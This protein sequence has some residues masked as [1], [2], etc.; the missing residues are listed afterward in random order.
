MNATMGRRE[1]LL[2]VALSLLWGGSFFFAE[3]ALVELP[4]LTVVLGRVGF[5][6][7]ALNGFILLSGRRMP[8]SPRLWGAFLVMGALNNLLPFSLI[9]W[10]QVHIDSGLAAILNATTPLFTVLLAHLLTADER[11]TRPRLAGVLLGFA[12]V[13]LMIGPGA[14]KGLGLAGLGQVAVLA[15]ALAYALA[16]IFGRR[17]K[18]LAPSTA[19]CGML[20]ATT[21]MMLP[22]ALVLERPWNLSPSAATWG[23]VLGL[24]LLSTVLAYL[25]YFRILASAGVTNLLLVTFLIPVSA[26]LLGTAF[27]GE[28]PDWT[29]YAGLAL[30]FAGLAAVDGRPLS[31]LRLSTSRPSPG[32]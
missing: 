5:A 10:A 4:P 19:A 8:G 9:V 23:A 13:A 26:L 2:L 7:L 30:I 28:R 29:A 27:L 21:V 3:L 15:A 6:A 17:F 22:L 14:L 31:Y 18:A 25:I 20:T 16:G 24:A 11:L 12:G 1:W 32:P